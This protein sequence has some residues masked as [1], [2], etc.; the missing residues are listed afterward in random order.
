M[1]IFAKT[2]IEL[3]QIMKALH[4]ELSTVSL[5]IH[6]AKTKILV[7]LNDTSIDHLIMHGIALDIISFDASYKYL[8]RFVLVDEDRRSIQISNRIRAAW[9]KYAQHRY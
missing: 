2:A 1:M 4:Y 3:Q 6:L 7:S 9:D 5:E 8:G